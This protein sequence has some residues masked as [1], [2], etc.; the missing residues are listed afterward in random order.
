VY[1]IFLVALLSS[2]EIYVAI[3]TGMAFGLSPN[4]ICVSTLVGGVIGVF[5]AAFLGQKI[6]A[7]IAKYRKP[8]P[9]TDS[10]KDKLMAKLWQ[11][12]GEFGVGFLG[13]FVVGAPISIGIG[14]GFGVEAKKL[15]KWCLLAVVLRCVI[16]SYF[17]DYIKNLF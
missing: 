13:T 17:F 9:K 2:F 16:Y 15:I 11:Q 14:I 3:G 8:K 1:K 5:V 6:K 7:F 12:Y 10:A 4:I